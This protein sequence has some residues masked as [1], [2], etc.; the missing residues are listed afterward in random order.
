MDLEC[1][2]SRLGWD[3]GGRHLTHAPGC[4]R[5]NEAAPE[6]TWSMQAADDRQHAIE[7]INDARQRLRGVRVLLEQY[8]MR[9]ASDVAYLQVKLDERLGVLLVAQADAGE[10]DEP[11]AGKT[12]DAWLR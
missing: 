9:L 4:P 3:D 5:F 12:V 7:V 8:D 10:L 1:T 11:F 6:R 2:C